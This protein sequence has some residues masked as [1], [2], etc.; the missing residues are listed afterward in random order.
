LENGR[1]FRVNDKNAELPKD[2]LLVSSA[3]FVMKGG[4]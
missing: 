1:Q 3:F 2:E 4:E